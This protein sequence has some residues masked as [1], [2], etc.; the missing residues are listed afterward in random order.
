VKGTNATDSDREASSG[1]SS[2]I[3]NVFVSGMSSGAAYGSLRPPP[4]FPALHVPDAASCPASAGRHHQRG[5]E[6]LALPF[7]R[8]S[9]DAAP[10]MYKSC[11]ERLNPHE[12]SDFVKKIKEK[13]IF[14]RF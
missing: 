9:R 5:A 3:E 2:S 7:R 1:A 12:R 4:G 6:K 11:T 10:N 8:T 13:I 14:S